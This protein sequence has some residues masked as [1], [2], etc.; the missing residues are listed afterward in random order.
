MIY[1]RQFIR[2]AWKEIGSRFDG[3]LIFSAFPPRVE[4]VTMP[5]SKAAS[6]LLWLFDFIT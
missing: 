6:A 5:P 1:C 3:C 4:V 2:H